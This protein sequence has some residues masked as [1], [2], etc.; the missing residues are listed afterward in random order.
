L[1][2]PPKA[3]LIIYSPPNKEVDKNPWELL[4]IDE[5]IKVW[6]YFDNNLVEATDNQLAIQK[7][8]ELYMFNAELNSWPD[9][10]EFGI[11]SISINK[12]KATIYFSS[13]SCPE[14]AGGL[15]HTVE[16]NGSGNWVITDSELLWLS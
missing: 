7:W 2:P 11:L 14:C 13:S 12:K 9:R 10:Y 1:N 16:R 6:W 15:I 5:P 4:R 8:E 3:N